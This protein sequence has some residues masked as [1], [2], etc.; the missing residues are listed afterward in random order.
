MSNHDPLWS[1]E[2]SLE[3]DHFSIQRRTYTL[4]TPTEFVLCETVPVIGLDISQHTNFGEF[5]PLTNGKADFNKIGRLTF[6][7]PGVPF[8]VRG[9]GGSPSALAFEICPTVFGRFLSDSHWDEQTLRACADVRDANIVSGLRQLNQELAYPSFGSDVL[10]ESL[11]LA[12]TV[13]LARFFRPPPS[14]RRSPRRSFSRAQ[15]AR[16]DDLIFQEKAIG[17][18][19]LASK[20]GLSIRTLTRTFKAATGKTIHEHIAAQRLQKAM[21]LLQNADL[22]LKQ[23]PSELGFQTYSGF[24]AAFRRQTG[25]TPAAFRQQHHFRC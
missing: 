25:L 21:A 18:A 7:P 2:A 16:I 9:S 15:L 19:A 1:V 13:Q 22:P 4:P 6:S 12:I 23:L 10:L 8:Y 11:G 5:K 17:L 20:C 24:S 3:S 14:P